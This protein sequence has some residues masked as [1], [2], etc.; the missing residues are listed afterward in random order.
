MSMSFGALIYSE[1]GVSCLFQ[2]LTGRPNLYD[3]DTMVCPFRKS[4]STIHAAVRRMVS[5]ML[6]GF[7]ALLLDGSSDFIHL[8]Y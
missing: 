5:V 8:L 4:T 7:T 2:V 1:T 6:M 3:D